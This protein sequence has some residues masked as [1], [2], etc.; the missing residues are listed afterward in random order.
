MSPGQHAQQ[1]PVALM[2]LSSQ[3]LSQMSVTAGVI[4]RD[5]A[6]TTAST[7]EGARDTKAP[8]AAA[9]T[10]TPSGHSSSSSTILE[11][12]KEKTNRESCSENLQRASCCV[13]AVLVNRQDEAD[14]P[15]HRRSSRLP[16]RTVSE[17]QL[18]QGSVRQR[19]Q[20][21]SHPGAVP[22]SSVRWELLL[23]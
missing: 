8:V 15:S 20:Q 21:V 9:E 10:L 18:Q 14:R 11:R 3:R 7:S 19:R 5:T 6:P 23:L 1:T 2:A 17:L 22:V 12:F 16:L 4:L 13:R